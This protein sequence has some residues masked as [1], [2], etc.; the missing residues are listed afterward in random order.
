MLHVQYSKTYTQWMISMSLHWDL[1]SVGVGPANESNWKCE[2]CCNQ[3]VCNQPMVQ[4][5]SDCGWKQGTKTTGACVS[6]CSALVVGPQEPQAAFTRRSP[7]SL[8]TFCSDP[9]WGFLTDQ[10]MCSEWQNH[11]KRVK[12]LK[13]IPRHKFAPPPWEI[14]FV[15]FFKGHEIAAHQQTTREKKVQLIPRTEPFRS[16]VQ[17][18]SQNIVRSSKHLWAS[19]GFCQKET[20][21]RLTHSPSCG[22]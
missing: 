19:P 11:E 16:T 14:R 17:T 5:F 7:C 9:G 2:V 20:K 1:S 21:A 4:H 10:Q 8:Q 13:G 3:N 12:S 18:G 6:W 15:C 22:C